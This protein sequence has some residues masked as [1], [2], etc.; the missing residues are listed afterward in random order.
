MR[1]GREASSLVVSML[2]G[3]L[4]T[5]SQVGFAAYNYCY[6]PTLAHPDC[7]RDA[8][9][10]PIPTPTPTPS[11]QDNVVGLTSN[12]GT[13]EGAIGTV[14]ARGGTNVCLALDKAVELFNG[15]GAQPGAR[16]NVILL[17]DGEGRV[18]YPSGVSYPPVACRPPG[19][20]GIAGCG[21]TEANEAALDVKT[22]QR[23][24]ALKNTGVEVYVVALLLC[25]P[26]DG[27]SASASYCAGVGNGDADTIADQRLLKCIASSPGHYVKISAASQ[28]PDAFRE[29]A[30]AIVSRGL[31]E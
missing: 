16:R 2:L 28:I 23:A 1:L 4:N 11:Y 29:I 8:G 24:T 10:L 27:Q 9:A 12:A 22:L 25:G 19:N 31:L 20:I 30:A 17:S 6:N 3:G 5:A 14:I 7:I 15:A 18:F 21:V 13:I 26:E